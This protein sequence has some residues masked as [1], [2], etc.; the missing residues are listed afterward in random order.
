MKIRLLREVKGAFHVDAATGTGHHD[1]KRGDIVDVP[2]S[3]ARRDVESKLA[4]PAGDNP[5]F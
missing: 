1:L 4:A 2:E 5:H 3:D